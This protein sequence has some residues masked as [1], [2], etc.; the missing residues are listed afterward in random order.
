M[1]V[2]AVSGDLM[3]AAVNGANGHHKGERLLYLMG[4]PPLKDYLDYLK[5]QATDGES[6]IPAM[7]AAE[8]RAA[9]LHIKDIAVDELGLWANNA[10]IT[11]LPEHLAQLREQLL[12]SPVYQ[13]S[14]RVGPSEIGMV[15]LDRLVVYQKHINLS[16]VQRLTQQFGPS[17]S[18]E[19]VFRLCLPMD[20]SNPPLQW[21]KTGKNSFVF[22][23]PSNDLRRLKSTVVEPAQLCN[24]PRSSEL[25]AGVAG[26]TIGF[27]SNFLHVIRA[28]G[29]MVL[30]NGS[31]RAYALRKVGITHVPLYHQPYGRTARISGHRNERSAT[32]PGSLSEASPALPI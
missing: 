32:Q 12:T 23:S 18:E 14:F 19:E 25:I 15:E 20:H 27:G 28:E 1:S 7:L 31:H 8:W 2:N 10:P 16:H 22:V 24:F 30:N 5:E 6:L 11:P 4:R 29:R 9:N 3:T 26:I 13:H 17:P 21:R